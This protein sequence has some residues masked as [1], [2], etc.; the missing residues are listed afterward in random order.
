MKKNLLTR[1]VK[2]VAVMTV[3]TSAAG[4][5]LTCPTLLGGVVAQADDVTTADTVPADAVKVSSISEFENALQNASVTKIS[6]ESSINFRKNITNIP[7]RDLTIYGNKNNGVVITSGKYSI[8]GKQNKKGTNVLTIVDSNIVGDQTVGRFFTG[9]SGNGP[10][11]Y[12]WDVVS[13]GNKY[14]GARFLHLSEGTLTFDG[15]NEIKT[16]AENAWVH[17]LNFTNGSTYIGE[18]AS[19][20]HG[21]F[22]AFY[23]NGSLRDG[24]IDGRVS[25][26][27]DANVDVV[28]SP[29]SDVNYYYP[30]FYDK[31]SRVDVGENAKFNVDAA[32]VAF[33][34]IPAAN[35]KNICSLN[36][37]ANS[38][39]KFNGR[40]GGNYATVKLQSYGAQVNMDEGSQLYIDGNSKKAV[41]ENIYEFSSFNMNG[42][43]NLEITNHNANSNIFRSDRNVFRGN[44]MSQVI[45]WAKTGGDYPDS[46]ITQTFDVSKFTFHVGVYGDGVDTEKNG[47][48]LSDSPL[49]NEQLQVGNNGKIRFVGSSGGFGG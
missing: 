9:G 30:V 7:N 2:S 47:E 11:S 43:E 3:A 26:G 49:M 39:V 4:F 23:F 14:A 18:A 45:T 34:F 29:Q 21:Q 44:N 19:K 20:D 40:G 42:A 32:G 41:V 13:R 28:I 38:V 22:S 33:Q 36:L 10:S 8:Y 17:D 16:R 1:M 25:I 6:V 27:N 24:K 15:W 37:A 5:A 48:I 46:Q 31:V 35:Y 12:G